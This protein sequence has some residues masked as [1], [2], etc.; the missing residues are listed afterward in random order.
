MIC[1][2]TVCIVGLFLLSQQAVDNPYLWEIRHQGVGVNLLMLIHSVLQKAVPPK[3]DFFFE[4]D[5][6]FCPCIQASDSSRVQDASTDIK[7][8]H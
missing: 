7:V 4:A 3:N 6:L 2:A 1:T 8:S 5:P